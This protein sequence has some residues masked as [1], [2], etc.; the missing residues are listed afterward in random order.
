MTSQGRHTTWNNIPTHEHRLAGVLGGTGPLL[1]NSPVLAGAPDGS[2]RPV[3]T[4]ATAGTKLNGGQSGVL[5]YEDPYTAFHGL[6]EGMT[7]LGDLTTVPVGVPCQYVHGDESGLELR[8]VPA[9]N[10]YGQRQYGA[11]TFYADHATLALYEY[12]G[13]TGDPEEPW[14]KVTEANGWLRVIAKTNFGDLQVVQTRL[15]R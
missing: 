4:L 13:P 8:N 10:F 1:Q 7:V 2:G 15:V 12:L 3:L 5:V 11:I 9:E 6:E 14:G